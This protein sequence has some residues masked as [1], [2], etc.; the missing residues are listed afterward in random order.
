MSRPKAQQA[1]TGTQEVTDNIASVNNSTADTG[2]AAAKQ[3]QASS[4]DLSKQSDVLKSTV[5][6][7]LADVRAA[8]R[9]TQAYEFHPRSQNRFLR[10]GAYAF[11]KRLIRFESVLHP[12]YFERLG[13]NPLCQTV[14]PIE[15]C[16]LSAAL[17]RKTRCPHSLTYR[18]F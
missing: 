2:P 16:P 12:G 9:Q 8:W 3:V 4:G 6:K 1:A 17:V 10:S 11:V 15:R 14:L 13:R 18:E 7:F 5:E